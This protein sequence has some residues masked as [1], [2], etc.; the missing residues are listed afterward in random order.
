MSL[1]CARDGQTIAGVATLQGVEAGWIVHLAPE[2]G[3]VGLV[4][5]ALSALAALRARHRFL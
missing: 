2:P 1:R 5:L 3:S 4:A